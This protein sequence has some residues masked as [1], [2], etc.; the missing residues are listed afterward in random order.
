MPDS[1]SNQPNQPTGSLRDCPDKPNCVC[2]QASRAEQRM[3]PLKFSG[4][5]AQ[6][7]ERIAAVLSNMPRARIVVQRENYLHAV[8]SS[9]VFRFRDDVEFMADRASGQLHFRSAARLGYY[10][11][12]AN[13]RRMKRLSELLSDQL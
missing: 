1:A 13:R 8:F 5:D 11:F 12:G 7:I 2:T 10:D 4:S 6:A 3:P 9:L